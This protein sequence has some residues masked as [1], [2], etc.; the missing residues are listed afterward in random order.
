MFEPA[1]RTNSPKLPGEYNLIFNK[2]IIIRY[3]KN[4]FYKN[5]RKERTNKFPYFPFSYGRHKK[6][7]KK[8]EYLKF[9]DNSKCVF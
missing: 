3:R 5:K 7:F 2:K 8:I 1:K 6:V 4:N 9:N